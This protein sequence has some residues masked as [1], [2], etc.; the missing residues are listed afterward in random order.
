MNLKLC[1][2]F[3]EMIPMYMQS[4][5]DHKWPTLAIRRY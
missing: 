4:E 5:V 3:Y 1:C 2:I